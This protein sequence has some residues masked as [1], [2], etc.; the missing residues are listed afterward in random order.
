M[1]VASSAKEA[2]VPGGHYVKVE[3]DNGIAWVAIDR[4]E[5][6]NAISPEVAAEMLSVFDALE[7]DT[8]CGVMVITGTGESFHAGMDIKEY[9]RATD[10]ISFEAREQIYRTNANWQWRRLLYFPKPTIAMVNGWCFGGGFNPVICCDLSIA[11]EKA[12]FGLSEVNWGILPAGNVLKAVSFVMSPRDAMYYSITGEAFDGRKAAEIRLVNE[13]VPKE[14]LRPRTEQLAR[15]LLQKNPTTVRA[16][17]HALRRVYEMS[18]EDSN[19]F[20]FA[21][22]DQM[23]LLD[24]ERGREQ[25]MRQFIDD[26]SYRP[27]LGHYSREK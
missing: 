6:R 5:K 16:T 22:L 23:R 24:P 14:R 1:L 12:M 3:F 17:K 7:V 25:G 2:P 11:D 19:D 4:P 9:F 8:R 21:K 18:W 27:G 13:A 20:L 10:G 15:V 26:K